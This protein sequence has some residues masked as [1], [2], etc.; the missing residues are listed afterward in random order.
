MLKNMKQI[1][2]YT[3]ALLATFATFSCSDKD[4]G[5]SYDESSDRLMRP[6]LRTNLTVSG[7]SNDP[8][9]CKVVGLNS[10]QLYWSKVE[11][12]TGYEIRVATSQSVLGSEENW[13]SEKFL[14]QDIIVGADQDQLLLENLEYSKDHYFSI[15]ALSDRGEAHHSLWWGLGDSG[16]WADYLKLRTED[17]YE[18]PYIVFAKNEITETGFTLHLDRSY[19]H[20]QL[21]TRK[22]TQEEL[23]IFDQYF[24]TKTDQYGNKVWNVDYLVIEVSESNPD[25]KMPEEYKKIALNDDMFDENGYAQIKLDGFETNAMY[26]VYVYDDNI[27]QKKSFVDAQ[28]N[29]D[30]TVRTKGIPGDPIVI[31]S[32]EQ[33]TIHFKLDGAEQVLQLP[34]AATP[35]QDLF[36]DFMTN[37]DFAEN[38]QFYLEGGKAYFLKG[39]LDVYKGFKLATNPEDIAAGKGR[40]KIY[41]YNDRVLRKDGNPSPAFFICGRDPQGSENPRISIDI[42]QFYLEDIDFSVPLASNIADKNADGSL[43][44]S[45]AMNNHADGMGFVLNDLFIKNCSFQGLCGGFYRAQANYPCVINNFTIDNIDLYNGGYY[46]TS[47][48]R[49]NFFHAHPEKNKASNIWKNF[50]FKNSTIYDCPL[51][52][53]MTHDK[54]NGYEWADDLNYHVTIENNTIINFACGNN[55]FFRLRYIP[56]G[57]SFTVKNNLFVLTRQDNDELRAKNLLQPGGDV[58]FING[59]GKAS[60]DFENNYST[61][62]N[63]TKGQIFTGNFPFDAAKN[64]FG[65]F[66]DEDIT[67]GPAGREGLT[68]KVADISAKDLMVQPNPPHIHGS[69]PNHYDHQC[70]GIDGTV[71]NPDATIR[72]DY[73]PGMVDLHFKNFDNVLVEKQI[74]AP[75]WRQK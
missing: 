17:R 25:A 9:L 66:S 56:G 51:G 71:T 54:D 33:D 48:R 60:F 4:E 43:T 29:L 32:A 16:H 58:R 62:D 64:S 65:G 57:S 7:G 23:N 26:N 38:Q 72:S 74:G 70:D 27:A 68:V 11:G 21:G 67:W 35:L 37:T 55:E 42:D 34:F 6:I 30:I 36:A 22:Y 50:T 41:L 5:Y 46:S 47:G 10:I 24:N 31:P 15:R 61:N 49:Y 13:S 39:G 73:Q 45:Y 63:L 18:V 12:A 20:T 2:L 52:R 14:K 53:F 44:N 3:F 28:Y 19:D 69:S 40:A 59:S 8:Y 75:K 1:L